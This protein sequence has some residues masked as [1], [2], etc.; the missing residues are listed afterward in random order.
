MEIIIKI[1]LITIVA[2]WLINLIWNPKIDKTRMGDVLLYYGKPGNRRYIKL[3]T[4]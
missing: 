4:N 2:S 1:I 3:W